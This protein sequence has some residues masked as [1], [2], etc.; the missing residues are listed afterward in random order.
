[1]RSFLLLI[2]RVML[3]LT[4]MM[5]TLSVLSAGSILIHLVSEETV[6]YNLADIEELNFA[7]ET[8]NVHLITGDPG[9]FNLSEIDQITFSEDLSVEDMLEFVSLIPIRF[10]RNYPNPFNPETTISFEL[11]QE[12]RTLIEIYNVK[13]Q[14]VRKL[15]DDTLEGGA[16]AIIWDGNND[17]HRQVG[18]GVYLYRVSV[19]GTEEFSKMIMLK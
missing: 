15:L 7:D 12:S 10:L 2:R 16:H 5:F 17:S 11:A 19:D 9:I 3:M 8:L 13:G 18:S 4:L 1:M 6:G 14:R